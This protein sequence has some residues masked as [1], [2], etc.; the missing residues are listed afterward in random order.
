MPLSHYNIAKAAAWVLMFCTVSHVDAQTDSE[1]VANVVARSELIQTG[2][3]SISTTTRELEPTSDL[4]NFRV[5]IKRQSG[6]HRLII[7]KEKGAPPPAGITFLSIGDLTARDEHTLFKEIAVSGD[8]WSSFNPAVPSTEIGKA[9]YSAIYTE[10]MPPS[11][12]V[13][14]NL[15]IQESFNGLTNSDDGLPWRQFLTCGTI[16]RRLIQF[17]HSCRSPDSIKE[18][19]DQEGVVLEWE[20]SQD[21]LREIWEENPPIFL[22]AS[23][24]SYLSVT[25]LPEKGYVVSEVRMQTLD[26][27]THYGVSNTGFRDVGS[28][29]FMPSVCEEFCV[30]PPN[31]Y[32]VVYE[33]KEA[34]NVNQEIPAEA[35]E[36]TLQPGT[37]VRNELPG[38]E[39]VFRIGETNAIDS[40]SAA[41]SHLPVASSPPPARWPASVVVAVLVG[42]A[43]IALVVVYLRKSNSGV[44]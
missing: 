43:L 9:E 35:F 20:L 12:K 19:S 33:I 7:P 41:A 31:M 11:G 26:R 28:G 30:S 25:T 22:Y 39:S 2:Q 37:R 1:I 34:R 27:H 36:L 17:F 16:P 4:P 3:F 38:Y 40:L 13:Q 18:P 8:Q 23:P 10:R 14:R 44:T 5:L 32:E 42:V 24:T 6:E 15:L 29:I 21:E